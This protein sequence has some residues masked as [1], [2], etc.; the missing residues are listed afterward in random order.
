MTPHS[1]IS[2]YS[3]WTLEWPRLNRM[4]HELGI[5]LVAEHLLTGVEP[6]KATGCHIFATERPVAWDVDAV[7]LVTQRM[8]DDALYRELK[9]DGAALER[10]GITGLYR[11]G[12]CV[13][14][15]L[16][17]DA[18]FDGHRLAREIDTDDPATALPFIRETRILGKTDEEFDATLQ[19][20]SSEDFVPSSRLTTLAVGVRS[21]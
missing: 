20:A 14:P 4:L 18:V 13:V 5:R 11:I 19:R 2:P 7:V 9:A 16:I 21:R 12:D 8:S 1:A 3:V 10:E 17:A 6:G 15:R